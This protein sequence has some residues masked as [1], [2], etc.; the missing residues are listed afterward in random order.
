MAATVS[1]SW[2][3]AALSYSFLAR[4]IK[5]TPEPC[6]LA[7]PFVLPVQAPLA[8]PHLD[9]ATASIDEPNCMHMFIR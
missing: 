7:V 4:S 3:A 1:L 6:T 5:V 8:T 2:R 9:D